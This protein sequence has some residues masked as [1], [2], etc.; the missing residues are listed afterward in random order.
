MGWGGVGG[1]GAGPFLFYVLA[2][3]NHAYANQV[4]MMCVLSVP[5]LDQVQGVLKISSNTRSR[6][7][8][9]TRTR[10]RRHFLVKIIELDMKWVHMARHGL[11]LRQDGAIWLRII[12]KPLLTPKQIKTSFKVCSKPAKLLWTE[13]WSHLAA[14]AQGFKILFPEFKHTQFAFISLVST[15]WPD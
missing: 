8:S 5:L 1:V 9:R 15:V 7:W 4:R 2:S 14:F 6:T 12:S 3:L 11:I 13:A 10:S